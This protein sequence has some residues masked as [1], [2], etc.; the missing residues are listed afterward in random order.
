MCFEIFG[1]LY[2]DGRIDDCG[3]RFVGE[4]APEKVSVDRPNIEM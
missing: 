3:E 2:Q 1:V 4:V